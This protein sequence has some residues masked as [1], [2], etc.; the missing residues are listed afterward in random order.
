MKKIF[1]FC[2]LFFAFSSFVQAQMERTVYQSFEIDSMETLD[3][4]L[5]GEYELIVWAGNSVLT[6]TN[7]QI[8]HASPS[9]LD[10]LIENGRYEI[11]SKIEPK[12]AAFTTKNKDRKPIKNA[13]KTECIEV[14]TLKV[15]VPDTFEWSK[16]D[17]KHLRKKT[18]VEAQENK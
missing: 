14:I 7:V 15:F 2:L 13:S 17:L 6:E 1:I 3:F 18:M 16:D 10:Y 5:V 11:L 8:S 9:I 4:D 12:S